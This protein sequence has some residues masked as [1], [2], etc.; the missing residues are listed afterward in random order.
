MLI[1]IKILYYIS[2]IN[3]TIGSFVA[4]MPPGHVVGFPAQGAHRHDR[5]A[6]RQR[7]PPGD[8]DVLSVSRPGE[9]AAQGS[10]RREVRAEFV[11]MVEGGR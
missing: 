3:F 6:R 7:R 9:G 4:W 5:D 8:A 1:K 11:Q 2:F 10:G